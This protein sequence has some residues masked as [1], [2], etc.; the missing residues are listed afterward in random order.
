MLAARRGNRL[1]GLRRRKF[2]NSLKDKDKALEI[3]TVLVRPATLADADLLSLVGSATFLDSFA[4]EHTGADILG[5]C[6][7]NH[8]AAT[9]RRWLDDPAARLW[10]A[11]D[12]A[13]H[14]PVG[15]LVLARAELPLADLRPTDYEV[16]RIYL[17]T[18]YHGRGSGR[19]L[20]QHAIAGARELGARRLLLGV[21]DRNTA[22]IAFYRRLGFQIVG[23]RAFWI[24]ARECHDHL[25]GLEFT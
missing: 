6:L 19:D 14:A 22:A 15:Y 24:G 21:Y 10:L 12:A 20:M 25:F 8:S 17:L 18:R 13:G 9:Y 2:H 1:A 23:E 4:G 5:H 16:K 3:V 11:E 7:R